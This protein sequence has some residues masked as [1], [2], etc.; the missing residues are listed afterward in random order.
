MARHLEIQAPDVL[1]PYTVF[2]CI[3][4]KLHMKVQLRSH[5]EARYLTEPCPKPRKIV[6]SHPIGPYKVVLQ[7]DGGAVFINLVVGSRIQRQY[8]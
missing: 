6:E 2:A 8:Q 7:D 1:G 5:E 4:G 3:A